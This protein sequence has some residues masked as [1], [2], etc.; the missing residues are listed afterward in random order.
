MNRPAAVWLALAAAVLFG[1]STPFI[2]LLIGDASAL[3]LAG[4]LYL[5]SGVGL[6]GPDLTHHGAPAHAQAATQQAWLVG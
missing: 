2:K 1:G 5:G 3:A 6:V 4:L